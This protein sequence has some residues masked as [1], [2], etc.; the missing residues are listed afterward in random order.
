MFVEIIVV[1][2]YTCLQARRQAEQERERE[3][4][5]EKQPPAQTHTCILDEEEVV[6]E[7]E[8]EGEYV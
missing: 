3:I 2:A 4:F 8:R 7:R 1:A 6:R 5:N